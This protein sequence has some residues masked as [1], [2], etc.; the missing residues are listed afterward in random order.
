MSKGFASN[1]RIVVLAIG[2]LAT[3]V[4]VGV[5][6][7]FLHVIDR[8]E[9]VRYIEKARRQILIERAKRGD[10]LAANND[11]V[12][13]T[14]HSMIQLGVDPQMLRPQDEGKWPELA[15]LLDLPLDQIKAVFANKTRPAQLDDLTDE[16]R[17]VRWS[18]LKEQIPESIY[19]QVTALGVKG[20]YG[21][22]VYRRAYPHNQL[23]SHVIGY[24]NKEGV[25]ALG[26]ENYADFYLRGQNGWRESE[27][28]GHQ[29]ELAQFRNREVAATNGYSVV[30]SLNTVIQSWVEGEM[31]HIATEFKPS[32]ASII[33]SDPATGFIQAMANYPTFDLNDYA[34]APLEAQK[35]FSI[36]DQ[37]DPGST[38]KVVAASGAL[39]EGLVKLD[40]RFDCSEEY[41]DYNGKH[42][43][44]MREDEKWDH[45]LTVAEILTHSSN[46]GAAQLAM[47]LG[48]QGFYNYA[49]AYG[50]GQRTGFPFGGEIAGDLNPPQKWSD[51]DITRLAAGYS[52]SV[53]PLQVHMAYSAIASGGELYRPQIIREIRDASGET[54]YRFGRAVR[55]RVISRAAAEQMAIALQGVANDGT[56]KNAAISGYQVAG[57]TGTARKLVN[58]SYSDVNHVTSFVGF[59][60]AS[61]PRVVIS[62]IVD[63][64]HVAA[65]LQWGATVAAPSFKRIG[66]QLI[67]Y[68]DIKPVI[69][70]DKSLLAMQGGR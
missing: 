65:S 26:L 31:E 60:P 70:P 37:I 11:D 32:H 21:N 68:L 55:R 20:V 53:T 7:V 50:F 38:F 36:T 35:N 5:R 14:S 22:R 28:D 43:H 51:V 29:R 63:D 58:G 13:A 39:N 4:G 8:P 27:K 9:L 67:Q 40:T 19:D 23:A 3:F 6:L 61:R 59:F 30:V 15:R 2:V 1:Y 41:I 42:L 34:K 64:P 66:E 46:H 18:V 16:D 48:D 33:V 49:K 24:L 47:K 17:E 52:V 10:I 54:V 12:L 44:L 57:K 25:P 62:I 56:G 45:P 69:E